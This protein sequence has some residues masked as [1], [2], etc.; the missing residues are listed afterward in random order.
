MIDQYEEDDDTVLVVVPLS[1]VML[2]EAIAN[3][4][5]DWAS[6]EEWEYIDDVRSIVV[7]DSHALFD[8]GMLS[9]PWNPELDDSQPRDYTTLPA[10]RPEI[11][12]YTL[13]QLSE[14]TDDE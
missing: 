6:S 9:Q 13:D 4:D 14:D 3:F 2:L 10:H 12:R 1:Y 7:E 5:P 8:V 11:A